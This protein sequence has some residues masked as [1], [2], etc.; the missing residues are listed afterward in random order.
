MRKIVFLNNFSFWI[1]NFTKS[2]LLTTFCQH[3]STN[4]IC[5]E[6]CAH[7]FLYELVES[8]NFTA[9]RWKSTWCCT[10]RNFSEKFSLHFWVD[11]LNKISYAVDEWDRNNTLNGRI[12]ELFIELARFTGIKMFLFTRNSCHRFGVTNAV[13]FM[14][15]KKSA[16]QMLRFW[17]KTVD[18]CDVWNQNKIIVI[19]HRSSFQLSLYLYKFHLW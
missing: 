4:W 6:I 8:G 15:F 17:H 1:R 3:H 11:F 12:F 10:I 18:S 14:S 19:F 5:W 2:S 13:I 16:Y 9:L 7:I